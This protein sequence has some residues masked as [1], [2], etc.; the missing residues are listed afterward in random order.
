MKNLVLLLAFWLPAG[1]YAQEE[2]QVFKL[3]ESGVKEI[4]SSQIIIEY[5]FKTEIYKVNESGVREILPEVVIEKRNEQDVDE[6]YYKKEN[7][8]N[9]TVHTFDTN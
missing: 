1:V 6:Q 9:S 2:T 8:D 5:E 4:Q 3:N 7:D